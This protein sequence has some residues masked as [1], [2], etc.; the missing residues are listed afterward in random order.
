MIYFFL[1]F[2]IVS[3]NES[4]ILKR[5]ILLNVSLVFLILIFISKDLKDPIPVSL[6]LTA[7]VVGVVNFSISLSLIM[8]LKKSFGYLK[9]E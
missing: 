5:L 8:K 1:L 3:F 6:M 9:F 4:N 2:V 7:I